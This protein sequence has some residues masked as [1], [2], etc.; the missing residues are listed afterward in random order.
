MT[1]G[2]RTYIANGFIVWDSH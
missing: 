1:N 2:N